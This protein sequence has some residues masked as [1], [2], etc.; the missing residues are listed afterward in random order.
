MGISVEGKKR[1]GGGPLLSVV[2]EKKE[3]TLRP[4]GVSAASWKKLKLWP[5]TLWIASESCQPP[6]APRPTKQPLESPERHNKEVV[7]RQLHPLRDTRH[8]AVRRLSEGSRSRR[9]TH[10]R[11][12]WRQG[13][14]AAG[15]KDAVSPYFTRRGRHRGH[16]QM[17]A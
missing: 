11:E 14:A 13:A 7:R 1:R 15:H 5:P 4:R 17:L 3:N 10:R 8:A 12:G 2:E 6:D 16:D 9:E